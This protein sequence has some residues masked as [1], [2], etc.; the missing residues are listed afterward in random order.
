MK[1]LSDHLGKIALIL[2]TIS[3]VGFVAVTPILGNEWGAQ[4]DEPHPKFIW[5]QTLALKVLIFSTALL[6]TGCVLIASEFIKPLVLTTENY[7]ASNRKEK[8]L[9]YSGIVGMAPLGL[10]FFASWLIVLLPHFFGFGAPNYNLEFEAL[11]FI[12]YSVAGLFFYSS[13]A[14]ITKSKRLL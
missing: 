6:S 9:R 11:A 12:S 4:T 13:H 2:I 1:K 10:G 8:L 7:S 5:Y 14:I 3:V